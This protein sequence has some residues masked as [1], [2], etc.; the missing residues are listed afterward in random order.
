MVE[1]QWSQCSLSSRPLALHVVETL[2]TSFCAQN[3]GWKG[4]TLCLHAA[5]RRRGG[6]ASTNRLFQDP[7]RQRHEHRVGRD[8]LHL[9]RHLM[10]VRVSFCEAM[11]AIACWVSAV[12][13]N[14]RNHLRIGSLQTVLDFDAPCVAQ[15]TSAQQRI[16]NTQAVGQGE[17]NGEGKE[18]ENEKEE[19][20]T[21]GQHEHQEEHQEEHEQES[22]RNRNRNRNMNRNKNKNQIWGRGQHRQPSER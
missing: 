2:S 17:G 9:Q 21:T 13:L 14:G 18:T 3:E 6:V 20:K 1:T 19:N 12:R 10:C 5:L 22:N 7:E 4:G 11:G 15:N 16:Q 8:G